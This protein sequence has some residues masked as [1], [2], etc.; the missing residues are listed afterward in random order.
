VLRLRPEVPDGC[1]LV[2]ARP[3]RALEDDIIDRSR[4]VQW[5]WR[6]S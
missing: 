5:R 4:D 3:V 1:Y 6:I 2:T